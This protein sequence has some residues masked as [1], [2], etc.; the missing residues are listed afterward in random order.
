LANGGATG[1]CV[2][3]TTTGSP[4]TGG[5]PDRQSR[6]RTVGRIPN[7]KKIYNLERLDKGATPERGVQGLRKTELK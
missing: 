7:R 6:T 3:T 4:K 5:D 1:F 2:T